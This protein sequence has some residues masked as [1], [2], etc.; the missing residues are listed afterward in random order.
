MPV[1]PKLLAELAQ[2]TGGTFYRAADGAALAAGLNGALDRMP[3]SLL[4]D[5]GHAAQPREAFGGPLAGALALLGAEAL[6][7]RTLLKVS[8]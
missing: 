1:N 4:S 5:G 2:T 8:P 3:R 6:L 7:R